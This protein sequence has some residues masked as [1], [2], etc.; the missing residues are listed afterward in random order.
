MAINL[1]R[2]ELL[3]IRLAVC[4]ARYGTLSSAAKA[5]HLSVSGASHRLQRL[6]QAFG[7]LLFRRHRLGLEPTIAGHLVASAGEHILRSLM[8]LADDVAQAE[9]QPRR[10]AKFLTLDEDSPDEEV[11]VLTMSPPGRS[12]SP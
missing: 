11:M 8:N 10:A 1:A 12:K 2:F 5:C 6:E 3:S 7:K 4:C 9:C